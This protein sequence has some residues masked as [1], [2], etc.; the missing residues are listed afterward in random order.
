MLP[1][2][3]FCDDGMVYSVL[4]V[5]VVTRYLQLL[6]SRNVPRVTE[7]L[8]FK[9][10]L[11]LIK[12][13]QLHTPIAVQDS[14]VLYS[15]EKPDLKA[16]VSIMKTKSFK[17]LSHSCYRDFFPYMKIFNISCFMIL[18]PME[19][20][21]ILKRQQDPISSQQMNHKFEGYT[22]VGKPSAFSLGN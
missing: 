15:T 12:F 4:Y 17:Q 1:N 3:T 2:R 10:N 19:L 6:S 9:F 11:P 20:L 13:K 5:T 7:E 14:T 18:Y 21:S 16:H 8:N 22:L